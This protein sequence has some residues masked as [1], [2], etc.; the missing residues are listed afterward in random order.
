VLLLVDHLAL[1]YVLHL[2]YVALKL[3]AHHL[4]LGLLNARYNVQED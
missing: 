4:P 1:R 2:L 3:G